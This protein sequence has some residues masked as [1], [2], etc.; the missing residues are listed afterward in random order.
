MLALQLA[1]DTA[2]AKAKAG[3]GMALVGVHSTTT[4][5]GM[6]A[7]YGERL[8]A[9]GLVGILA[10][11][12]PEFVSMVPGGDGVFG[13]N[14]ICFAFPQ[15]GEAPFVVDFATAAI[16]YYGV[17]GL[18]HARRPSCRRTTPAPRGP[19]KC[20]PTITHTHTHTHTWHVVLQPNRGS[21]ATVD[22]KQV[23]KAKSLGQQLPAGVAFDPK[24]HPTTD[25]DAALAGTLGTFGGHKGAALALCV[26]LLG[27]A[28]PG[29]GVVA[30]ATNPKSKS[31]GHT[32][33]A[34]DP[35]LLVDDF[36]DRVRKVCI[37]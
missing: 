15:A 10:A 27:A 23:L 3:G 21:A 29:A 37:G 8:A 17:G 18:Q 30:D 1:V 36:P 28:L 35:A 20:P 19:T 11:T 16:A 33:I 25:P 7:Y 9:Q 31:W 4:S 6:L 26:E 13:T 14:P 5:S 34:L 2:T 12:S 24:G 22:T 32:V